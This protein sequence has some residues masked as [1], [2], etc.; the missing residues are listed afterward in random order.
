MAHEMSELQT[1]VDD[2]PSVR[3]PGDSWAI[4]ESVGA[5]ALGVAAA[6]AAESARPDA[7]IRDPY[8]YLLV[9]AAGPVWAE[10]AGGAS[11]PYGNDDRGRRLDQ[12]SRSYQA[13]R[14][15]YFDEHFAAGTAAGI[16][17][18]VILAAGLDSRAYRL[19]W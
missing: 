17:Q 16:R 18:V 2:V 4:T 15:H 13:V 14:T 12:M 9:S 11:A 5:T 10:L 6:R 1:S 19:D 3:R 7:L 8:A